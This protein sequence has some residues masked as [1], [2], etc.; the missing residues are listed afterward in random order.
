MATEIEVPSQHRYIRPTS[1]SMFW[2]GLLSALPGLTVSVGRNRETPP[3][4][5]ETWPLPSEEVVGYDSL[6]DVRPKEV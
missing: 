5:R 6:R 1:G 2:W 4:Y 3:D